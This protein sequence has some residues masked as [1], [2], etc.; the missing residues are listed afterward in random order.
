MTTA[1]QHAATAARLR[2][3]VL[4]D[5]RVLLNYLE[6]NPGAPVD[7]HAA[8]IDFC[9]LT[10]DDEDGFAQ[11]RRAAEALG[12]RTVTS[13]AGH[14]SATLAFGSASY[15]IFYVPNGSPIAVPAHC[16][17]CTHDC[18]DRRGHVRVTRSIELV[19]A[20]ARDHTECNCGRDWPCEL[21][22]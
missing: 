8:R 1:V 22:S 14:L 4:S 20:P 13:N 17:C 6:S 11:V 9:V 10:E 16:A 7:H 2:V 5:L 18:G 19:G 12:V 15:R 3:E 21:A